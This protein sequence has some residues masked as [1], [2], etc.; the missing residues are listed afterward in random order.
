LSEPHSNTLVNC[1]HICQDVTKKGNMLARN[2]KV[3]LLPQS[4]RTT[5]RRTV[6]SISKNTAIRYY[7]ATWFYSISVHH[8]PFLEDVFTFAIWK[9]SCAFYFHIL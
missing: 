8:V 9:A 2:K 3:C 7:S 5:T 1:D 6:W 4:W